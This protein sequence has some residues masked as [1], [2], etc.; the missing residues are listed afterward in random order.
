[1]R[2]S[3]FYT[4]IWPATCRLSLL[5]RNQYHHNMSISGDFRRMAGNGTG[6]AGLPGRAWPRYDL[7]LF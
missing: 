3:T 7:G 1:V 2:H 6:D 4:Q 5:W